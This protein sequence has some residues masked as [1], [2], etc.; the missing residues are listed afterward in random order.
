MS[1]TPQ[2][3]VNI[4]GQEQDDSK[5]LINQAQWIRQYNDERREQ[6]NDELFARDDYEVIESLKKVIL[7][8][9]RDAYFTIKVTNFT[10]VEDYAQ[11]ISILHAYEQEKIDR[12]KNNKKM[13]NPY[14]YIN[15]KDSDIML[16]LVDY[17]V[18][19]N[20]IEKPD[21]ETFQVIIKI[22]RIVDKYYYRINGNLFSAIY[23]IVDGSTY[24]NTSSTSNKQSVT[25]KTIFMPTRIYRNAYA[26]TDHNNCD[27][28]YIVYS[29]RIFNKN[30]LVIEYLLAKFGLAGMIDFMGFTE[31]INITG[32]YVGDPDSYCF[33]KNEVFIEVPKFLFDNDAALQ[34][35]VMSLY[36]YLPKDATMDKINDITTWLK[37]LAVRFNSKDTVEK[38]LSVLDSLESIYDINTYETIRLPEQDKANIYCI[39]RWMV[40]EFP[41]LRLKDNT[42]ISTKKVR[43]PDYMSAS[44]AN[45]VSKGIY[46]ASDNQ[47]KITAR[48]IKRYIFVEPDFLIDKIV[49]DKLV[50]FRNSVNDNDAFTALKYSYK[51]ISGLGE[52]KGTTIP[53][54]YRHIPV[55]SL[56]RLDPDASSATDP[57]LT[58]IICP[59]AEITNSSFAEKDYM[60]PNSWEDDFDN[61]LKQYVAT[62]GQMQLVTFQDSLPDIFDMIDMK[63][64]KEKLEMVKQAQEVA[65]NAMRCVDDTCVFESGTI[66]PNGDLVIFY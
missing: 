66:L 57:G 30:I 31:I 40:R 60:E 6:F 7:S 22:P 27:V 50:G 56:G 10:V 19:V 64:K 9:Q 39:L 28:K 29:S 1:N 5:E 23:Q 16:L 18:S 54:S 34:C 15:V 59:M 2:V 35:T 41:A 38:G 3:Q 32:H 49:K 33:N 4:T 36:R 12:N 17:Y 20:D 11:I 8:C 21:S 61:L 26:T 48:D 14:D 51:G 43:R 62:K 13:T 63:E 47:K 45:K 44:Y 42:D 52:Q 25:F 53:D 55:Q 65:I 46:R 37:S 58:G 24:N